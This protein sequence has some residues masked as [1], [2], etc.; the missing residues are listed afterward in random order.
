M[1]VPG[2][3]YTACPSCRVQVWHVRG[4]L[5]CAGSTWWEGVLG[6]VLFSNVVLFRRVTTLGT[7][8]NGGGGHVVG[9]AYAVGPSCP[10]QVGVCV[11]DVVNGPCMVVQS[12]GDSLVQQCCTF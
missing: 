3:A 10:A 1:H 2:N 5:F 9:Y 7:M 4:R 11:V 8:W 6:T 12:L